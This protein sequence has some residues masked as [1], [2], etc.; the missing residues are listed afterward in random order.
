MKRGGKKKSAQKQLAN[1]GVDFTRGFVATGLLSLFQDRDPLRI[2]RA[3]AAR[4]LRH[5]LQ[6][7]VALSAGS[8]AAEALRQQDYAT[9]MTALA[10]GA[11]GVLAI[12]KLLRRPALPHTIEG[13]QA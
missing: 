10:G 7:G 6:G 5:A 13:E 1:V 2:G 4:I 3:D 12:E 9:A 11:V 8:A